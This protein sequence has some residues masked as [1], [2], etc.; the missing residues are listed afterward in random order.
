MGTLKDALHRTI[1]RKDKSVAQIAE[2]I[3]IS[4]NYLYRAALPDQDN[5]PECTSGVRFP[6]SKLVPLI[7]ATA[8]FQVL[9]VV[10]H[11]L[12]RVSF[13]IPQHHMSTDQVLEAAITAAAEFG[14]L[15]AEVRFS[16]EDGDLSRKELARIEKEGHEAIA[17]IMQVIEIARRAR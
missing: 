1:H 5:G 3:G 12:G 11:A 7:R 9:D 6:L 8:D 13:P 17:A 10:E 4:E 16:I 15:M 2:E 14:D